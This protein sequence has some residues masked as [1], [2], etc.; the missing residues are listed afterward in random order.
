MLAASSASAVPAVATIRNPAST[1][2]RAASAPTAL[3][4]SASD[5]K[6]QPLVG[7]RSP[8][9]SWLLANASPKVVSMPM[10]SPV[11][12]IS[13][14]STVSASGKR[15]NGRTASLMAT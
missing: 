15:L 8:A 9:A 14:P 5:M 13:G 11:L 7:S 12:R 4:R 2:R 1:N 10:T 3:S 6:T